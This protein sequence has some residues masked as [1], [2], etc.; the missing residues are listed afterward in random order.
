MSTAGLW[1]T[2]EGTGNEVTL[3]T[4]LPGT[5]FDTYLS[6]YEGTC[7]DLTC[8][9]GNDDQSETTG[10]D[11]ICPVAFVASTVTMNTAQR[12]RILCSCLA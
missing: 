6:V 3:T 12:P 8:V 4:C 2:F 10:F 5:N 1:F 11:D 7:G 9:A